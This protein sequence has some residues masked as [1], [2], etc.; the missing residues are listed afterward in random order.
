M[1]CDTIVAIATAPSPAALG[2]V[3][4]SGP[5]SHRILRRLFDQEIND[6]EVCFGYVRDPDDGSVVD[7][8][9]VVAM[10]GPHT[11]TREDT[12]EITCHGNPIALE[13]VVSLALSAGARAAN[14]GEFTLRAF[15]NGRIDLAQAE[16]VLEVIGAQSDVSLRHAVSGLRGR[17]S[18]PIGEVRDL[19]LHLQAYLTACI[20]FPED[21]VEV[22]IEIKPGQ[23]LAEVI[24]R[25]EEL[26]KLADAGM[27]YRH[28]VRAAI[29]GRPNVG[30][31]SVLNR[32]VGED[33]AIVTDVPGTTRDTVEEII[34]VE[35][36]PFRLIDTA[37]MHPTN[38]HVENL[39]IERS[40]L[41]IDQA[42]LVITVIDSSN[43][44]THEDHRIASLQ[45]KRPSILVANKSD[46]PLVADLSSLGSNPVLCSA[47]TGDG[48][49]KLHAAMVRATLGGK[50]VS[51]DDV[52]VTNVRHK[53][54][55]ER[56]LSSVRAAGEA[57]TNGTPADFVTIDLGAAL[58]ALGEITGEDASEDLLDRIFSQFCIGK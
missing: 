22:Q 57:I 23:I 30:K 1:Y 39:G 13:R 54:A 52:V 41:A 4:L 45:D 56:A 14:P 15:M 12:A 18:K 47:S 5:D 25:I 27:A 9:I 43:V 46:L 10:Q 35:G 37:G 33:R 44:L 26:L 48:I 51:P 58:S 49:D 53:D 36:I 28:G 16:S 34:K 11:Y 38:D 8:A 42:D 19:L 40:R 55:L 29:V 3:R 24:G 7:E 50:V 20:D 17:L 6:R 31:S 32:L 21:E 2:I